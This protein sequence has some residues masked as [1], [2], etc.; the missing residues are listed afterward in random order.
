MKARCAAWPCAAAAALCLASGPARAAFEDAA[1]DAGHALVTF[2]T[3]MVG[4]FFAAGAF[5]WLKALFTRGPKAL[6]G[7]QKI[8][9]PPFENVV[10]YR[11]GRFVR[12][13]TPG[14]HWVPTTHCHLIRV[15]MRPE[16]VQIAQGTVTTD[17]IPVVLRCLVRIQLRD[18]KAAVE[19][20]SNY[21]AEVQ[22]WLQSL[23][24]KAGEEHS[25]KDLHSEQE[26]VNAKAKDRAATVLSS[27]GVECLDFELM[28]TEASNKLPELE[29]RE[30]GFRAGA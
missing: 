12:V 17:R 10:F 3:V 21:R 22:A 6:L 14:M 11:R 23:T 29:S 19:S 13:L 18:P 27:M 28:Q 30:F 2:G 7:L 5:A 25:L 15:D 16:A 1:N 4:L 26:T 20:A 9:V 8:A 24:K